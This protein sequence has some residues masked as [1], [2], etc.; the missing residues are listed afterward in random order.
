MDVVFR[1]FK[2]YGMSNKRKYRD[3]YVVFLCNVLLDY[4]L[5][6]LLYV[7]IL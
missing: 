4:R 2:I 7:I 3:A 5:G 6:I 1:M